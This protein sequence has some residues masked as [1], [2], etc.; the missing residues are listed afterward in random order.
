MKL[1]KI[2]ELKEY[3]LVLIQKKLPKKRL[4]FEKSL[5]CSFTE[6]ISKLFLSFSSVTSSS[7]GARC[8][9]HTE[10]SPVHK[11]IVRFAF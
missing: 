5:L 11:N 1:I 6:M 3:S 4:G 9:Y 8:W 2:P 7:Y 10:V